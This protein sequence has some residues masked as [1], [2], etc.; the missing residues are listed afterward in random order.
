MKFSASKRI[1]LREV[2]QN[3][4]VIKVKGQEEESPVYDV[5][6]L[7]RKSI[8]SLLPSLRKRQGKSPS[9]LLSQTSQSTISVDSNETRVSYRVVASALRYFVT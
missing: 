1:H 6:L 4:K 5:P 9:P 7:S 3:L 8:M 2:T